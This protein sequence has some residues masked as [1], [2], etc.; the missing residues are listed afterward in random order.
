MEFGEMWERLAQELV[1]WRDAAI[2]SL[3]NLVVAI[4]AVVAFYFLSKLVR[5]LT[6]R[7]MAKTHA[8]EA[9][10]S[11][12]VAFASSA[13]IILGVIVALW[14]MHL[15]GAVAS[16]LAGAG[17]VGLAIGFAFQ[18]LASNLISGMG[19][20][21]TQQKPFRVGD[22]IETNGEWAKVTAIHFRTT[23]L[24]TFEGTRV[25]L[26]NKSVFQEKVINYST[27]TRRVSIDCGVSY[28]DDLERVREVL[29]EALE[30]LSMRDANKPVQ[31]LFDAFGDSSV[32]FKARYW[33]DTD[34]HDFL[35]AKSEGV[36]AIKKTLDANDFMIPFPIR[37]LDFGIRGGVKLAEALPKNVRSISATKGKEASDAAA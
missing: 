29:I 21:L 18:D 17:V 26:P 28:G 11:L 3:P 7:A 15:D 9:A 23:E 4:V 13:T 2:A 5:R 34:A 36:L 24:E 8:N 6:T 19:L 30:K 32:N 31:I 12:V 1:E 35:E 16:I 22:I 27:G 10:R 20:A 37:T 33:V 14:A 25:I